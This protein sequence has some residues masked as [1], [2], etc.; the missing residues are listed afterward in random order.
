MGPI[1]A[2]WHLLGLFVPA[3]ATGALA[4]ARGQAGCGAR[5]L[6]RHAAGAGWR[7]GLRPPG[8]WRCWPGW[9]CFGRDGRMLSYAAMVVAAALALWWAGFGRRGA[10]PERPRSAVGCA[11][12]ALA[13]R[14]ASARAANAGRPR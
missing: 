5:E 2:F 6:A 10:E 8:R 3:L 1:D 7:C 14:P 13:Q 9:C 11:C 4:A 12:S